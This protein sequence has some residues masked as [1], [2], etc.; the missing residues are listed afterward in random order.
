MIVDLSVEE[1]RMLKGIIN[2]IQGRVIDKN[3]NQLIW[4]KDSEKHKE[5][6]EEWT[7]E[8]IDEWMFLQTIKKKLEQVEKLK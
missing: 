5:M 1:A 3:M 4:F 8:T 7:L 6:I 2:G